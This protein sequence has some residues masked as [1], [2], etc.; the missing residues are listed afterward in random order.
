MTNINNAKSILRM[1]NLFFED[2][3]FHRVTNLPSSETKMEL[4]VDDPDRNGE[5]F[6]MRV[7]SRIEGEGKYI[8]S[9]TLKGEFYVQGGLKEENQFLTTNA[10][11]IMF[12]YLRSQVTLL[13]SQPHLS[14]IVLPVLN[15]NAV[16]RTE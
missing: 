12:P 8:L 11:A 14:P 4:S 2:I 15:I 13:T 7:H 3:S 1:E 16:M 9:V 6:T 5:L 10:V